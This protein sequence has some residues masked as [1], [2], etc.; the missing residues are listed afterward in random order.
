MNK[1]VKILEIL[2]VI[3]LI[4][5]IILS[6]LLFSKN[7]NIIKVSEQKE[8]LETEGSAYISMKEHF[9][10]MSKLEAVI[11]TE[12]N[13]KLW[14]QKA[15]IE[16]ENY[17]NIN[18]VL[19]D[20]TAVTTLSNS[21]EAVDYMVT[22]QDTNNCIRQKI[23]DNTDV[24]II[25]LKSSYAKSKILENDGWRSMI[26]ART[27]LVNSILSNNLYTTLSASASKTNSTPDSGS[28]VT[29]SISTQTNDLVLRVTGNMMFQSG[30]AYNRSIELKV[31]GS[32][33]GYERQTDYGYTNGF[34]VTANNT[35]ATKGAKIDVSVSG[36][37][38]WNGSSE[39]C[40]IMV[41]RATAYVLR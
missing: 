40:N 36:N 38:S 12:D 5:I 32:R 4:V 23:L 8:Q 22:S 13:W 21:Q 9:A 18:E 20:T 33:I 3:L 25:M 10:E 24:M 41:S 35:V 30:G 19:A 17:A 15:Q 7:I 11:E 6:V 28:G 2:V 37:V 34:A 29:A 26:L 39:S 27:S 14:A 1:K 31:G 16:I